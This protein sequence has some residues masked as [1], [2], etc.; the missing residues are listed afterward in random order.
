MYE[1]EIPVLGEIWRTVKVQGL[2]FNEQ[3]VI[4]VKRM[5]CPIVL[6][7]YFWSRLLSFDFKKNTLVLH[8]IKEVELMK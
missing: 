4:V 6:G 3:W 7:I 8:G 5:I 1:E 2:K